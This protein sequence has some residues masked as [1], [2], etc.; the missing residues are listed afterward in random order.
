M[1][2]I[3]RPTHGL[4]LSGTGLIPALV[5]GALAGYLFTGDLFL[6]PPVSILAALCWG[7][8]AAFLFLQGV[9]LV[10]QTFSLL[11]DPLPADAN[12]ANRP[13]VDA[14]KERL[15]TGPLSTR[16]A[17]LLEVWMNGWDPRAVIEMARHQSASARRSTGPEAVFMFILLLVAFWSSGQDLITLGALLGL[18]LALAARHALLTQED[19]YIERR[20]LARLPGNL[21]QTAMTASELAGELGGRIEQAFQKYIPQPRETAE[22][23]RASIEQATQGVA[24]QIKEL[25]E[26]LAQNQA[27]MVQTW[28][29][30]AKTTTSELRDVEKALSTVV[31]DLTGG[32][33][34]NAKQMQQVLTHHTQELKKLFDEAGAFLKHSNVEGAGQFQAAM[35]THMEL[36]TQNSGAW[37]KQL[38]D[39]LSTHIAT[40]KDATK[41]LSAQMEKIASVSGRVEEVLHV[42]AA[43]EETLKGMASSEEFRKTMEGLRLH[44]EASDTLL[45]ELSKPRTIRLVETE[46]GLTAEA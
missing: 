20:L 42:N 44:I 7:I 17:R 10:G 19:S 32:L 8:V 13:G 18:G 36:M 21:P 9:D 45:R 39:V 34:Q 22:A 30:A 29:S 24:A 25:H 2:K 33:S 4:S 41:N 3:K 38:Q 40:L 35:K 5:M 28:S 15:G 23:L 31:G 46:A 11:A 37:N 26:S 27:A 12:L 16:L 1:T 43:V 6:T 14:L